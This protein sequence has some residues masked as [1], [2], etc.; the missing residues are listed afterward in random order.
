MS[1]GSVTKQDG[2][3]HAS[4]INLLTVTPQASQALFAKS[5][6]IATLRRDLESADSILSD[7]RRPRL[8]GYYREAAAG[9]ASRFLLDSYVSGDFAPRVRQLLQASASL[10]QLQTAVNALKTETQETIEAVEKK[11]L[12]TPISSYSGEVRIPPSY[13]LRMMEAF[14]SIPILHLRET[15]QPIGREEAK[16]LLDLKVRRGGLERLR[17]VQQTVQNL[18]GVTVEAFQADS[19][20]DSAEMDID[21]FLVEANGAGIREAL[22][23]ILDLELKAPKLVLIEEPEVH[24]HPGLENA[25]HTYLQEKQSAM[26]MFVTTH[27][28]NFVDSVSFQNIYLVSRSEALRTQCEQVDAG[29]GATR[30]PAELGLRLSTVFMFD[31]LVFVEGPSDEAV[32]REFAKTLGNDLTRANV[33]FVQMGGVRNFA[34]YAAEGTLDILVRRRVQMW[35]VIDRDE[36][37]EEEIERM[38]KRLGERARLFIP[39]RRELENYLL[40]AEAVTKLI[41][42]KKRRSA[43]QTNVPNGKD[44]EAALHRA[45]VSLKDA[46]VKLRLENKVLRPIYLQSRGLEGQINE[47]LEFA[48]NEVAARTEGLAA[49]TTEITRE[50]GTDWGPQKAYQVAPG[51]RILDL[52]CKEFGVGFDKDKGDSARLSRCIPKAEIHYDIKRLLQEITD[53]SSNT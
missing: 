17:I 25:V 4:G 53:G 7:E 23:L 42:G 19:P 47:R 24:L 20:R 2:K 14:G 34:H 35:F 26:Q 45:A 44:V 33:G 50:V 46:V 36:R 16:Q 29:E 52:A 6:Q 43:D 30:I 8:E 3:L 39:D 21:D 31:R 1:L 18:L 41:S 9:R 27:S 12:D 22:R 48:R 28:T 32:L 5:Q 51:A 15:K 49:Q 10:E 37:E 38:L 11:D 40:V 13:A